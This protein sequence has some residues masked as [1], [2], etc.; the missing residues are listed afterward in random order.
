MTIVDLQKA[1]SSLAVLSTKELAHLERIL[2]THINE[3]IPTYDLLQQSEF[4]SINLSNSVACIEALSIEEKGAFHQVL[5]L[6]LQ[7]HLPVQ[8]TEGVGNIEFKTFTR[9]RTNA[10][11]GEEQKKVYGPYAYLRIWTSKGDG[12]KRT[13]SLRSVYLGKEI[14][15]ALQKNLVTEQ[16]VIAAYHSGK[17]DDLKNDVKKLL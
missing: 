9:R 4:T 11:T 15:V 5:L 12:L 6:L 1:Q 7:A 16:Q 17:I 10:S 14:S 2:Q 8:R 13:R 3:Q